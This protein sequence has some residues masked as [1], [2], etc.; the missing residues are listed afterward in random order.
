MIMPDSEGIYYCDNDDFRTQDIFSFLD[1]CELEFEWHLKVAPKYSLNLYMFLRTLWEM[2]IHDDLD[3][4]EE[5]IQSIALVLTNASTDENFEEFM[6]ECNVRVGM[7]KMGEELER[8]L[9][10]DRD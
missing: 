6:Q 5:S 9:K 8:L 4:I 10:N 3:A 7:H 2:A 1:H